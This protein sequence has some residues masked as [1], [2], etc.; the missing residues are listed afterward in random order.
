[1][2]AI[3]KGKWKLH[4]AKGAMFA[5]LPDPLNG[6]YDL[7]TDI[8]EEHNVFDQHPDIVQELRAAADTM[9]QD[10]G[11]SLTGVSG[12]GCRPIGRVDNPKPLA[13]YNESHP[14]IVAA[15]DTPDTNVMG[16]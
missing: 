14:Y 7:E 5:R 10:L 3:R 15:Y 2:E 1:M 11:D 12:N 13:V 6:L 8:G 4:F 16:G 9:R